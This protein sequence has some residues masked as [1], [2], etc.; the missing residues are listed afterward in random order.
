MGE[1][2]K[3]RWRCRRGTLELD[4]LLARYLEFGYFKAA[5]AQRRAFERLLACEDSLLL[6]LFTSDDQPDDPELRAIVAEIRI[7]SSGNTGA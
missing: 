2:D 3:L 6:R 7:F 1:I 4:L 5:K